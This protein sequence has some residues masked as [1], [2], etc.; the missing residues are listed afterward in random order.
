VISLL[1]STRPPFI[2]GKKWYTRNKHGICL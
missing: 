2:M 1:I